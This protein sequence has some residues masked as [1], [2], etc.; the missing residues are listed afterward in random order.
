MI[1]DIEFVLKQC[2]PCCK[3]AKSRTNE[4]PALSLKITGLLDR[5]SVD[6]TFGLS[7]TEEGYKGIIVMIDHLSKYPYAVP[8][9]TKSG[10]EIARH[11]FTFISMFGAPK[12][13][14]S[15]Q[16]KEFVN[17]VVKELLSTS[18]VDYRVTSTYMPRTNGVTKKFNGTL[19]LLTKTNKTGL[20]GSF[21]SSSL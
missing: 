17:E 3:Y 6:L 21:R 1:K 11:L 2:I 16:G 5:V 7:E 19:N 20:N 12:E 8:I 15:D 14:L 4:H 13:I 9:K 10:S 18:G